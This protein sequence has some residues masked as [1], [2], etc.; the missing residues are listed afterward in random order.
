MVQ[1]A[2]RSMYIVFAGGKWGETELLP[3]VDNKWCHCGSVV[4]VLRL[5][6]YPEK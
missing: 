1:F 6:R 5:H 2:S 4:A 3:L